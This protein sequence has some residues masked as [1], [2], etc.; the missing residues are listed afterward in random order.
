MHELKSAHPRKWQILFV[1]E[2]LY[3]FSPFI[4]L[5]VLEYEIRKVSYVIHILYELD[6]IQV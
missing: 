3:F 2:K 4:Y 5:G 6:E 1:G